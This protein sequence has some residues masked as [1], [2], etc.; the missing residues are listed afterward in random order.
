M[1]LDFF[2]ILL[3]KDPLYCRS[4]VPI[5]LL[6]ALKL[7]LVGIVVHADSSSM[8]DP[9]AFRAF[10]VCIG[11]AQ[12]SPP[13]QHTCFGVKGIGHLSG[14]ICSESLKAGLRQRKRNADD[15]ALGGEIVSHIGQG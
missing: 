11:N 15:R 9:S 6:L 10:R 4:E 8:V 13:Q 14:L 3:A 2:I 1:P 12:L 7:V 5:P